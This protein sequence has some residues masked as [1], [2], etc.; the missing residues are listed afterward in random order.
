V[1]F[2][3]AI[4]ERDKKQLRGQEERF[5]L[6]RTRRVPSRQKRKKPET[7]A[8]MRNK[9]K[10]RGKKIR[11]RGSTTNYDHASLQ[12]KINPT[13]C[14]RREKGSRG[15]IVISADVHSINP[16]SR[17]EISSISAKRLG[18][19]G[20]KSKPIYPTQAWKKKDELNV[21]TWFFFFLS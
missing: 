10:D 12:P 7:N 14:R 13:S 11:D 5:A 20:Q 19:G 2:F 17:G 9:S 21:E 6:L 18:R 8:A 3:C 16:I 4:A 1:F 15:R